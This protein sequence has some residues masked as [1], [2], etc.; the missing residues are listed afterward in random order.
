MTAKL[1]PTVFRMRT[2]VLNSSFKPTIQFLVQVKKITSEIVRQKE[3][4]KD[5]K[6]PKSVTIF[7]VKPLERE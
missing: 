3:Y 2:T 7:G 6:L 4:A 5:F 1:L